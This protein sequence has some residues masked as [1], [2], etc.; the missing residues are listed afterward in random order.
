MLGVGQLLQQAAQRRAEEGEGGGVA[1][2]QGRQRGGLRRAEG[3]P[4]PA[5]EREYLRADRL[6]GGPER[7]ELVW[8]Q[9]P[10]VIVGL[11]Q[12][13]ALAGERQRLQQLQLVVEVVLEPEHDVAARCESV[14]VEPVAPLE[15]LQQRALGAPA[16]L[17][18]E[19]RTDD[20][21]L[22]LRDRRH[23]T[24]VQHVLPREH[25]PAEARLAKRVSR[26]LAVRDVQE[27]PELRVAPAARE[28]GRA[29]GAAVERVAGAPEHARKLVADAV[30]ARE[31]RV[32]LVDLLGQP[33]ADRLVR[34]AAAGEARVLGDLVEREAE[35]LRL[36]DRLDEADGLL[37]VGAVAVR[38]S[39]G[40]GQETAALVVAERLD[41]HSRA[42]RDLADPHGEASLDL[43][44]G[45][46]VKRGL[47]ALR[48]K[49]LP[50]DRRSGV[51]RVRRSRTRRAAGPAL[52]RGV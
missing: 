8:A 2:E 31:L 40:L 52:A 9:R 19:A 37:V 11:D 51:R 42:S 18:Q 17:A 45:T 46:G 35:A 36:L 16:A 21:Q 25:G 20:P 32:D 49:C 29:A 3:I 5:C 14:R 24:L 33:H 44:P 47:T 12:L 43:Y 6:A 22:L 13:G 26:A 48:F 38:R 34:A 7:L 39:S 30:Q 23:R 10:E 41:V 27:P 28:V 1:V 15:R 50:R 4:G